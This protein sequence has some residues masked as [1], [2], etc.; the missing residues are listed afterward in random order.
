[1]QNKEIFCINV[2]KWKES[3]KE[4]GIPPDWLTNDNWK[5]KYL[6]CSLSIG[7]RAA[8]AVPFWAK[9]NTITEFLAQFSLCKVN[10]LMIKL[11]AIHN[12]N[13]AMNNFWFIN[14]FGTFWLI[15]R[16]IP[17]SLF[18]I[19]KLYMEFCVK[20]KMIADILAWEDHVK[21]K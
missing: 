17:T 1:M 8:A 3:K 20:A 12:E 15:F 18:W 9:A 4:R 16:L 21:Y 19:W 7:T 6:L 5:R 14:F 2:Y 11:K 10:R 13:S